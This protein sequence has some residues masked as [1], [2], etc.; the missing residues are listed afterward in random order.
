[1]ENSPPDGIHPFTMLGHW[2][3]EDFTY[4][5]QIELDTKLLAYPFKNPLLHTEMTQT[6]EDLEGKECPCD[7]LGDE[8]GI[9]RLFGEFSEPI[10]REKDFATLE[11][12][13]EDKDVYRP[14]FDGEVRV[15]NTENSTEFFF[16]SDKL[17]G[18]WL[19]RSLP[20][21]F[22]QTFLEGEK[23]QLFWKPDTKE[24]MMSEQLK[25]LQLLPL[26]HKSVTLLAPKFLRTSF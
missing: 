18:R 16:N 5:L 2:K 9:S 13:T 23:M 7:V 3:E 17:T 8:A 26:I 24:T 20:N 19:L 4:E 11:G 1:M 22:S 25:N 15:L 6:L 21:I 14:I 12:V 10:E